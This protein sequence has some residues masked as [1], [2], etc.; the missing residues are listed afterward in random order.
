MI[1]IESPY[2][3]FASIA[4]LQGAAD[5]AGMAFVGPSEDDAPAVRGWDVAGLMSYGPLTCGVGF[6]AMAVIWW[7]I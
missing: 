3:Q 1:K 4:G 7:V 6:T 5:A 2:K